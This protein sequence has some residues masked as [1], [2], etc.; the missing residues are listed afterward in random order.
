MIRIFYHV[1]PKDLEAEV[2]WLKTQKVFPAVQHSWDWKAEKPISVI[3][4]IV[5][6]ATALA[7]KLRRNLDVQTTWKKR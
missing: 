6:E 5:D 7:L 4:C 3:G 1:D 2:Q